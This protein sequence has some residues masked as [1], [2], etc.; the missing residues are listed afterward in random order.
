MQVKAIWFATMTNVILPNYCEPYQG[1][2]KVLASGVSVISFG[3]VGTKFSRKFK[4]S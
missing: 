4:I 2:L 3:Y 1:T